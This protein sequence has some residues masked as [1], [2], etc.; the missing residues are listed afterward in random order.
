[1]SILEAQGMVERY[2][3][4]FLNQSHVRCHLRTIVKSF[5][6]MYC[7]ILV[8]YSTGCLEQVLASSR[9]QTDPNTSL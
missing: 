6:N 1:M 5:Y 4:H 3:V 8:F 9:S 7:W 2:K